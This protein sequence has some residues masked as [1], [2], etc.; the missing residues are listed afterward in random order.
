MENTPAL[1]Q[2]TNYLHLRKA[3]LDK[4]VSPTFQKILANTIC[5]KKFY[6]IAGKNICIHYYHQLFLD[7]FSLALS[8]AEINPPLEIDLTIEVFDSRHTGIDF[9]PPWN[10]EEY[11]FKTKAQ[12]HSLP[13]DNFLGAYL[14]GEE[15]VNLYDISQKTAYFWTYDVKKLPQWTTAA[16]FRT[17]LHWFLS[18]H[19]THMMH[20]AVVSVNNN[21]VLLTAKGGSGK[22]TTALACLYNGMDYLADDYVGVKLDKQPIA[23]SLYNSGKLLPDAIDKFPNIS[24][25]IFKKGEEKILFFLNSLFP[26]QIKLQAPIKAI[27]IPVIKHTQKSV[28]VE[29]S[30]SRAMI[31]LAPTTLFQLPLA[32]DTKMQAIKNIILHTPC[33]FLEMSSDSKEVAAIIRHFLDTTS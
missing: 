27:F 15:T 21:A 25:G 22:S 19:D 1:I 30:K 11:I 26:K 3:Y 5:Q 14:Y 4:V 20:G 32:K 16:P 2:T 6:R 9:I 31:A 12:A 24:R 29:A 8:H 28:L 23:H 18:E 10:S 33:Y 13:D 17:L 7:H